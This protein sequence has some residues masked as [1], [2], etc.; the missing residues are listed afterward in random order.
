MQNFYLTIPR[1][2][3]YIPINLDKYPI[4]GSEC[5]VKIKMKT[6]QQ[7]QAP[8]FRMLD[9]F[10]VSEKIT[11][12]DNTL[13]ASFLFSFAKFKRNRYIGYLCAAPSAI[14]WAM[15]G[16]NWTSSTMARLCVVP[17]PRFNDY[18]IQPKENI[19]NDDKNDSKKVERFNFKGLFGRNRNVNLLKF[20]EELN[21]F[22]K[23]QYRKSSPFTGMISSSSDN[24]IFKQGDTPMEVSMQYKRKMFARTKL[25]CV[26]FV[27]TIY[28]ICYT[29]A[30]TFSDELY[31]YEP[32]SVPEHPEHC[33]SI[34]TMFLSGAILLSQ[35]FREFRSR[36]LEYITS[37]YNWI[38][39]AAIAL[40]A[41]AFGLLL[42]GSDIW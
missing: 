20:F 14:Y 16:E 41:A 5:N 29:T 8:S 9:N 30:V 22:E 13:Q 36:K 11:K 23:I 19:Y 37:F 31:N 28:Y 25:F 1:K 38:D 33:E 17:L 35:E 3:S 21:V 39:L 12:Y 18:K 42:T 27:H 24:Q 7:D 15:F 40:P 32:G 34:I 4:L 6:L 26:L 2:L 10:S